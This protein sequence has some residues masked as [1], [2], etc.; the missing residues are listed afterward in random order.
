MSL[1]YICVS[2]ASPH[3]WSSKSSLVGVAKDYS[4]LSSVEGSKCLSL[5]D[6]KHDWMHINLFPINP[7]YP[8]ALVYFG[9]VL[10]N[11]S[12]RCL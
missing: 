6:V 2:Q 4:E 12:F 3:V 8:S 9:V 11:V 7:V 5:S 10:N 1:C